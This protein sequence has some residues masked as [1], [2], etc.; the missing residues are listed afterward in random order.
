MS[1]IPLLQAQ[2]SLTTEQ[3]HELHLEYK[4]ESQINEV[5]VLR[6]LRNERTILIYLRIQAFITVT[7]IFIVSFFKLHFHIRLIELCITGIWSS[8]NA[9]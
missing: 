5:Y 8:I 3:Q 2:F 9:I 6:F 4:Y 7:I 1:D